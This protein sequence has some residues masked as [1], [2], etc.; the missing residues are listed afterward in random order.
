MSTDILWTNFSV[1]NYPSIFKNALL[2][3]SNSLTMIKIKTCQS[4]F[5]LCLKV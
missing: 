2:I 4:S 1:F 5:G 3:F